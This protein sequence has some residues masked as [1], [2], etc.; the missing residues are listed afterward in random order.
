MTNRLVHRILTLIVASTT[1]WLVVSSCDSG[2]DQ[3]APRPSTTAPTSPTNPTPTGTPAG[4]QVPTTPNN[5]TPTTPTLSPVNPNATPFEAFCTALGQ[6]TDVTPKMTRIQPSMFCQG[7]PPANGLVPPTPLFQNELPQQYLYTGSGDPKVK[8]LR[9][10]ESAQGETGVTGGGAMLVATTPADYMNRV[11]AWSTKSS[12]DSQAAFPTLR[13]EGLVSRNSIP[14]PKT[15]SHHI[16][17]SR[18]QIELAMPIGGNAK[19]EI[20]H[21]QYMLAEGKAYLVFETF[22]PP[23][24]TPDIGP[25]DHQMAAAILAHP[26]GTLIVS[27]VYVRAKAPAIFSSVAESTIQKGIRDAMKTLHAMA[28]QVV[29]QNMPAPT[30]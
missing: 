19:Y 3:L 1:L 11:A 10:T 9:P 12:R 14:L 5:S 22:A 7:P 6:L 13:V 20:L 21:N 8:T 26:S 15:G 16:R 18:F 27:M 25:Q 4:P 24:G 17:G 30:P 23:S 28:G 2:R 29:S